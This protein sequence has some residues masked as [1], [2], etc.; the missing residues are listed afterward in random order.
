MCLT[1]AVRLC[2]WRRGRRGAGLVRD[3]ALG[4]I[5]RAA[6]D[7][8]ARPHPRVR[9]PLRRTAPQT[10]PP[11]HRTPS[12]NA[13]EILKP[14]PHDLS[15]GSDGTRIGEDGGRGPRGGPCHRR[16]CARALGRGPDPFHLRQRSRGMR[17]DREM[18]A[19]VLCRAD[20]VDV[21][22]EG[23]RLQGVPCPEYDLKKRRAGAGG[24][25][26]GRSR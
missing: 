6:T 4:H 10:A 21:G 12:G 17:V 15:A 8:R 9:P 7:G 3:A 24:P 5:P 23:D 2:L 18:D 14:R 19:L 1:D 26:D 20:E 22:G 11:S 16:R 13:P 25:R